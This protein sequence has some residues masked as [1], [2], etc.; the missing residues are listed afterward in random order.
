DIIV[1]VICGTAAGLAAAFVLPSTAAGWFSLTIAEA[2]TAAASSAGQG[3]LSGAIA[4]AASSATTVAGQNIS[5]TGLEPMIQEVA[6]WKRV[7]EI[8]RAGLEMTPLSKASHALSLA[9]ADLIA[10]VRVFEAG[11]ETKLTEASITSTISKLETQEAELTKATTELTTKVSELKALKISVQAIDPKAKSV[12]QVERDI[13]VMWMSELAYDSNI[14]DLDAIEDH[15]GPK[16]LKIV[17]FGWYTSDADEN[18]AIEQARS[19][20][21]FLKAEAS[22]G[23]VPAG[24]VIGGPHK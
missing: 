23:E 17:D 1:G 6:M 20:A 12:Q 22:K 19:D 5:S 16:G 21:M 15:I 13:W 14:L 24:Q 18:A 4:A 11:G 2:G 7:S 3:I 8:Y 10:D 9:L